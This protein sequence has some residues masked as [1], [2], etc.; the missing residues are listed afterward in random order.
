MK[1][2]VKIAPDGSMDNKDGEPGN[3]EVTKIVLS[4]KTKL[5]CKKNDHSHVKLWSLF[6]LN[7]EKSTSLCCNNVCRD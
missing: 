4:I 6:N 3:E 2:V 5:K 1:E 7:L